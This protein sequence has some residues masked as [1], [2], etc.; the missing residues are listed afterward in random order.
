MPVFASLPPQYMDTLP[1]CPITNTASLL[2]HSGRM[3][4]IDRITRYGDDFVEAGAQVSPNHILLLDDKLP[5]TAFIELMAQAVGAYAGIQARKN[6]RSV[7]LGFLLGTRK[8]EIFAQSV[9][10]GTHLLATAHMSIQDAGGMG[11]FDCELRWTD[12]PETSSETLPSDGILARASLNVYSPE[13][14]AGTT[15]AV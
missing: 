1:E 15:D 4:L 3:V 13:H 2:P 11:V 9:P 8:L 14:P 10:I 5:Y 12:A 7:R 6:A